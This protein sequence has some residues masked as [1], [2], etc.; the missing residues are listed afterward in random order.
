MSTP[1]NSAAVSPVA[2]P[3]EWTVQRILEWTTNHLTQHG[4]ESPRLDAEILLAHSRGCA[5]IELY[6]RFAEVLTDEERATM[7]E[8]VKRR[9]KAEP[10]AYLV[11]HKEFYNLSFQVTADVL[12]PRPDTETLVM[13]T[14]SHLGDQ[15]E[16]TIL[17]IGTGSGCIPITLAKRHS[18]VRITSVDISEAAS[19]V[20]KSNAETHEV[21]DRI[22]FQI[23]DLF[24]PLES[25]TQFDLI[26]SNPPYIKEDDIAELDPDVRLHEPHLALNGGA[27][28]L[29]VI[30]RLIETAPQ[31]LKPGGWLLFEI[32]EDEGN[33]CRELFTAN[34][35]YTNIQII[36][37]LNKHDRVAKAQLA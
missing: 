25:G 2:K 37:D 35:S 27:D 20:A 22:D 24:S 7:R 11:G 1:E 3:D 17:E 13:E 31:W 16:S 4:S 34:G 29:D 28:G 36:K 5:R 8:L 14:L 32:G 6:T 30:R 15:A 21:A 33:A 18:S 10:V 23:G 12:I 9:A 26:V 19:D